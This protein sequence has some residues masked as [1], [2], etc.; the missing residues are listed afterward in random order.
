MVP[1]EKRGREGEWW[2]EPAA[3]CSLRVAERQLV[4][5]FLG[6]LEAAD[7]PYTVASTCKLD[8]QPDL[9]TWHLEVTMAVDAPLSDV[10]A[11]LTD[12]GVVVGSRAGVAHVQQNRG[13]PETCSS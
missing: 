4:E 5:H 12:E 6:H 7:I 1:R 8:G 9:D 13:R 2:T 11:L 10:A 3:R